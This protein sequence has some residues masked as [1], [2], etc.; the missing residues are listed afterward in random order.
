VPRN[1][2]SVWKTLFKQGSECSDLGRHGME[3][4][5]NK[6]RTCKGQASSRSKIREPRGTECVRIFVRL[7]Y[8]GR[9]PVTHDHQCS[10][11]APTING[12][13]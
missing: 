6:Y 11:L 7:S 9:L 13:S 2:D 4:I 10:G 8:D 1:L 3:M 12:K 5:P